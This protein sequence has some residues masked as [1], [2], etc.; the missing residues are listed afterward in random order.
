MNNG[1]AGGPVFPAQAAQ[2]IRQLIGNSNNKPGFQA[3]FLQGDLFQVEPCS[4]LHDQDRLVVGA[5]EGDQSRYSGVVHLLQNEGFVFQTILEV[6]GQV[7][8]GE[9]EHM[10]RPRR[11][12]TRKAAGK[13]KAIGTLANQFN[14]PVTQ[15]AELG[16]AKRHPVL[17]LLGIIVAEQVDRLLFRY[18]ELLKMLFLLHHS[19]LAHMQQHGLGRLQIALPEVAEP[20]DGAAVNNAVIAGPADRHDRPLNHLTIGIETR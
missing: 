9:L 8:A 15:L 1:A 16:N 19:P 17:E 7:D 11:I 20:R 12:Q 5:L 2:D 10:F 14:I 6:L 3:A 13:H 4:A 18:I